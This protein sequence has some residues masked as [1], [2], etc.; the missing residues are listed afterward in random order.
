MLVL[1]VAVVLC[2]LII[3]VL[4]VYLVCRLF[5]PTLLIL[6]AWVVVRRIRRMKNTERDRER[7]R[8]NKEGG[9]GRFWTA[10]K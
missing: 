8:I 2:G 5:K 4:E 1:I 10:G 7:E 6:Y 3:A 9:D